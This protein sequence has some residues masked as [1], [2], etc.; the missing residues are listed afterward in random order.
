MLVGAAALLSGLYARD[1]T[2]ILP[3]LVLIGLAGLHAG[4]AIAALRYRF[5]RRRT[6]SPGKNS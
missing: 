2:W 4:I 3:Y 1:W 6:R 5:R